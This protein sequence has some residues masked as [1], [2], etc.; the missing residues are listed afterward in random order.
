MKQSCQTSLDL[1]VQLPIN[2][3]YERQRNILNYNIVIQSAE[4]RLWE[5]TDYPIPQT[6][7]L[8]F[9]KEK[10][11]R[12]REIKGEHKDLKKLK[13]AQTAKINYKIFLKK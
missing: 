9:K 6:N 1:Q 12:E 7:R 8:Q 10:K 11:K 3:N 4:S 2:K 5:G 13:T